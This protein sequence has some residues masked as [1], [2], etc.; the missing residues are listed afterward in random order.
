MYLSYVEIMR[1]NPQK[2]SIPKLF[3]PSIFIFLVIWGAI[4]SKVPGIISYISIIILAVVWLLLTNF[5][6]GFLYRLPV[7]R[8]RA[9]I[10]QG[11]TVFIAIAFV[12]LEYASNDG[13]GMGWTIVFLILIILILVVN[14][15]A[16][17]Y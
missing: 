6:G 7:H 3:Y 11:L 10:N 13:L 1:S 14:A 4:I 9:T 5:K 16:V 15:G 2:F 12:V 8:I 17:A